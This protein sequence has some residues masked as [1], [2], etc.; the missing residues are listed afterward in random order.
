[1]RT[2]VRDGEG[3]AGQGG[4][5][6][7]RRI[8]L[9]FLA[10]AFAATNAT[11]QT[12]ANAQ[13]GATAGPSA[14]TI[15]SGTTFNAVLVGSL[16]SKRMKPGDPVTARMTE[17]ALA[18]GTVVLPRNTRLVG[19]VT[20]ATTRT[21][22][23]AEASLGFQFDKAVLKSGEEVP[24]TAILQALAP[25]MEINLAASMDTGAPPAS[26][27]GSSSGTHTP[28]I[29]AAGGTVNNQ[30]N[31]A[32][33]SANQVAAASEAAANSSVQGATS[34]AASTRRAGGGIPGPGQLA[35][36]TRGMVQMKG[37]TLKAAASATASSDA[38]APYLTSA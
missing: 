22:G 19:H 21:S 23:D 10:G 38:A 8:L 15:A 34:S 5:G 2:P 1:M 36:N 11:E 27:P 13:A 29:I 3:P 37:I 31:A 14:T 28:T 17:E 6:A 30:L 25:P 18:G 35:P 33:N 24:L 7:V 20:R 4:F 26:N 12:A 32:V 9:L 16:D